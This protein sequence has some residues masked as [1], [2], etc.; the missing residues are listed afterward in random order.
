M[1]KIE[2]I[3]AELDRRIAIY[4]AQRKKAI[5]RSFDRGSISGRKV[6]LEEFK[7]FVQSLLKE[8][9]N[10][11]IEKEISAYI[12]NNFDVLNDE[13]LEKRG[14]DPLT[15]FDIAHTAVHFLKFQ[16][17]LFLKNAIDGPYIRRNRH[18]KKNVLNGLDLTCDELQGFKDGQKLKVIFVPVDNQ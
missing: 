4:D 14:G 12:S 8:P 15:T 7:V 9:T 2:Q 16:K 10:E 1:S 17:E 3:I 13:T 11:D 6:A 5:P 18:T